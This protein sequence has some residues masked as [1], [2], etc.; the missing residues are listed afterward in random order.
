[1]VKNPTGS[2]TTGHCTGLPSRSWASRNVFILPGW[3]VPK[4]QVY[5]RSS[6]IIC[7]PG[8]GLAVFRQM[9]DRAAGTE[10]S[11]RRAGGQPANIP[12]NIE[13][14]VRLGGAHPVNS[15]NARD[16]AKRSPLEQFKGWIDR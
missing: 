5:V 15:V 13:G 2:P 9:A 1:M 6:T 10:I 3:Q 16:V 11:S 8:I 14:N 7:S 12:A 4:W